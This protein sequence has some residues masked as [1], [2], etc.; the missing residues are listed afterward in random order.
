MPQL[1]DTLETF[2]TER[3]LESD[4]SHVN[5]LDRIARTAR[6]LIRWAMLDHYS[7]DTPELGKLREAAHL[8]DRLAKKHGKLAFCYEAGPCGYGLYRQLTALGYDCV[9]IAPSLVPTRPG[10]GRGLDSG[11]S[12]TF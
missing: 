5:D 12:L 2:P 9:V 4:L 1:L 11:C 8:V 7:G 3:R 6:Q 10:L